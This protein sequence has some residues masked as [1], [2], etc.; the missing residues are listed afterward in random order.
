MATGYT[1]IG[2]M[3]IPYEK[4]DP[5]KPVKKA[6][7]VEPVCP[8]PDPEPVAQKSFLESAVEAVEEVVKPKRRGRQKKNDD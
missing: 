4:P 2:K 1:R 7:K 3:L 6:Q 5:V 8:M